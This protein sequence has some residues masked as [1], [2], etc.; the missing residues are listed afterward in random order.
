[1]EELADQYCH[2]HQNLLLLRSRAAPTS[3]IIGAGSRVSFGFIVLQSRIGAGATHQFRLPCYDIVVVHHF[4]EFRI[5]RLC[6]LKDLNFLH[7]LNEIQIS[8]NYFGFNLNFP[9]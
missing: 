9:C 4:F 6:F 7:N 5:S 3:C 2:M 8:R 1:M